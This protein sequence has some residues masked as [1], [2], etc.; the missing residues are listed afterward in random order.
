VTADVLR[1]AATKLRNRVQPVLEESGVD[2]ASDVPW[3][4]AS[5]EC[6]DMGTA[7]HAYVAAIHPAVVLEV[8]YWLDAVAEKHSPVE[9]QECDPETGVPDLK[10]PLP[11]F[12]RG[13]TDSEYVEAV[14]SGDTIDK[15]AAVVPFPCSDAGH[16]F[17]VAT[18]C[19]AG[20]P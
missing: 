2:D 13:C 6:A 17:V 10:R 15:A 16:A 4:D 11:P 12:C 14:E 9:W 1:R 19:I 8:A 5:D 3:F 7:V 18:I 20:F